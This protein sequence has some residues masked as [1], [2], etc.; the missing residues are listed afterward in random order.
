M[1]EVVSDSEHDPPNADL[2]A[3]RERAPRRHRQSAR[4]ASALFVPRQSGHLL[5]PARNERAGDNRR[6]GVQR[7]H[8]FVQSRHHRSLQ[9]RPVGAPVVVLQEAREPSYRAAASADDFLPVSPLLRINRIHLPRTA[10]RLNAALRRF[11]AN[12]LLVSRVCIPTDLG[13]CPSH[14]CQHGIGHRHRR[15]CPTTCSAADLRHPRAHWAA[16]R[17]CRSCGPRP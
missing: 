15:V 6:E 14:D 17:P 8:P 10:A 13:S 1:A 11:E 9:P 4:R 7:M 5:P 2:C 12:L 3:L 16:A